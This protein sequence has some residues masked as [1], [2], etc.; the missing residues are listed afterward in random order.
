[1]FKNH[2]DIAGN[3]HILAQNKQKIHLVTYS[4]NG[5]KFVSYCRKFRFQIFENQTLSGTIAPEVRTGGSESS[6]I[7]IRAIIFIIKE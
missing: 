2:M 5:N 1:M 3:M 7:I 4:C 6:G